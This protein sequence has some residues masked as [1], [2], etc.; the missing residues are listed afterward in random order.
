MRSTSLVDLEVTSSCMSGRI[1]R[2][3]TTEDSLGPSSPAY[4]ASSFWSRPNSSCSS[5]RSVRSASELFVR[6]DADSSVVELARKS[7]DS[8]DMHPRPDQD[9]DLELEEID[10][11]GWA[12]EQGHVRRWHIE[13]VALSNMVGAN[14]SA[15]SPMDSR[16]TCAQEFFLPG[17]TTSFDT[18]PL[19]DGCDECKSATTKASTSRGVH[20]NQPCPHLVLDIKV[21][22]GG[23]PSP[24]LNS[25]QSNCKPKT[26][27]LRR[28]KVVPVDN[29]PVDIPQ[30][31]EEVEAPHYR[32][33]V[34]PKIPQMDVEARPIVYAPPQA[35][36]LPPQP[37]KV[38]PPLPW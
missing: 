24:S 25:F 18:T 1:S 35:P 2:P 36:M 10:C 23:H 30:P 37:P 14:Q 20:A 11:G 38:S 29:T 17:E 4:S 27:T 28:C 33:V 31:Q 22:G 26:R 13:N 15:P 12:Q 8:Q 3:S 6:R 16:L 5:R 34:E 32:R 19:A 9:C 21:S 7:N